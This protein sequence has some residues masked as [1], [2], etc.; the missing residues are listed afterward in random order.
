[1]LSDANGVKKK[2]EHTIATVAT[3]IRKIH[4]LGPAAKGPESKSPRISRRHPGEQA[5]ARFYALVVTPRGPFGDQNVD[6]ESTILCTIVTP[7]V[8]RL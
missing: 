6:T 7:E 4:R 5:C 2:I 3:K 1:M 8:W